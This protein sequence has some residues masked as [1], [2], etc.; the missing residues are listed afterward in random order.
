MATERGFIKGRDDC[1]K[2]DDK[3]MCVRDNYTVQIN[4]LRQGYP[5]ART[6][7]EAGISKGPLSV[8]CQGLEA[9][10]SATFVNFDPG[11][12]YLAWL[13]HSLCHERKSRTNCC[14]PGSCTLATAADATR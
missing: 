6:A 5:D 2:S 4:D 14:L 12:V 13:D 11:A 3:S 9:V 7:D 10:I 8:R 1:W